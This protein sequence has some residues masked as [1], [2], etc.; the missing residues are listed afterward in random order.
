MASFGAG[1]ITVFS[2]TYERAQ[3]LASLVRGRAVTGSEMLEALRTSDILVGCAS[4]PHHVVGVP[5][6]QAAIADRE[7]QPLVVIDLGVPRNVDPSVAELPDVRLFNID[8]LEA[9]MAKHVEERE[10]EIERVGAIIAEE[11]AEFCRC[12]SHTGAAAL[13]SEL[14]AKAEEVRQECLKL[15]ARRQWSEEETAAVDY[16]TDLLVRKLLH[17]PITA[18]RQAA[19]E[20]AGDTDMVEA[21]RKLF[22]LAGEEAG[23]TGGQVSGSD[24]E[25]EALAHSAINV[26]HPKGGSGAR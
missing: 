7:G 21:V 26:I 13:I 18:L 15:A 8:N 23:T 2:R 5:E 24:P 6:I 3:G 25:A 16:L 11:V 4:A 22:G 14:R 19:G 17:G 20:C 10:A 9:V 12:P 1:P